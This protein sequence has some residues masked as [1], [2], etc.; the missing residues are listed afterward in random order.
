[1][2][3]KNFTHQKMIAKTFSGLENV[4]AEELRTLGAKDV[5]TMQRGVEFWGDTRLLYRANLALRTALRILL[6]IHT[7]EVTNEMSLY[8]EAKAIDWQKIITVRQTFAVDSVVRS[9][10]F[11]HSQYVALKVKDAIADRFRDDNRGRRPSVDAKYPDMLV[12]IHINEDKA[13]I[14]LDTSGKSLHQRGYREEMTQA[15]LNEVLAAGIIAI[16]GWNGEKIL[17]DGMCGSGT[18]GIEAAMRVGGIAAQRC[19]DYFSF[20]KWK[21]FDAELFE[22][23]KN[24]SLAKKEDVPKFQIFASDIN[25]DA[26]KIAKSNAR[27]AGVVRWIQYDLENFFD[28]TAENLIPLEEGEEG[29]APPQPPTEGGIIVLNPPY[30]ERLKIADVKKLYQ[31]IGDHLKREW[32]GWTAWVFTGNL[33]AAKFIGLRP[34]AKVHLFNGAIECRLL[35][36]EVF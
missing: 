25:K 30:D 4:L 31:D 19:R 5:K 21:T 26:L 17:V 23:V 35:K 10:I 22:S 15:P 6:P 7:F 33:E 16:T 2:I 34:T 14:S 18:L 9:T 20:A 13:T 8:Y 24:T 12:N 29:E 1:M 32:K 28:R 36:F 11:N 27:K 3:T